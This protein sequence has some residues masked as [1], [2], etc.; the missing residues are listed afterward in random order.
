MT[1]VEAARADGL[2]AGRRAGGGRARARPVG[3]AEPTSAELAAAAWSK[4]YDFPVVS[5][6]EL[7]AL[8]KE[9]EAEA[10]GTVHLPR[11][12]PR[13]RPD[14]LARERGHRRRLARARGR[15]ADDA[16]A[17][18]FDARSRGCAVVLVRAPARLRAG[19]GRA[20]G[21]PLSSTSRR[22]GTAKPRVARWSTPFVTLT[23]T[24]TAGRFFLRGHE[25]R[26]QEF[27]ERRRRRPDADW[28]PL[29]VSRA[30][31]R[32][33][34]A[35]VRRDASVACS[36]HD[37][38]YDNVY[39]DRREDAHH[40]E[41]RDLLERATRRR[42]RR[43]MAP[44]YERRRRDVLRRRE[45]GGGARRVVDSDK[46]EHNTHNNRRRPRGGGYAPRPRRAVARRRRR[47]GRLDALR[48]SS[49]LGPG[50]NAHQIAKTTA[51][52]PAGVEILGVLCA[53]FV[54]FTSARQALADARSASRGAT[55]DTR[56]RRRRPARRSRRRRWRPSR[57]PDEAL[58]DFKRIRE[59]KTRARRDGAAR[60]AH[61]GV[62]RVTRPT[63][64][65][66][67][68]TPPWDRAPKSA[69]RA[70]AATFCANENETR[71]RGNGRRK[72]NR[73]RRRRAA[74][75]RRAGVFS[76]VRRVAD[77]AAFVL[78]VLG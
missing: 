38:V 9:M 18:R 21:S 62:L 47:R 67:R 50:R 10:G 6:A 30:R 17:S 43:R 48:R 54:L 41:A 28:E 19:N 61:G 15:A 57:A 11:G 1:D 72:L 71:R 76:G 52:V 59:T 37:V 8:A 46:N 34:A 42:R 16:S 35:A 73:K 69:L 64:R 14:E 13:V 23:P 66:R 58:A 78:A 26:W 55:D 40:R 29:E 33:G 51:R 3:G 4:L 20:A 75:R 56:K 53:P 32:R 5:P 77:A 27:A 2:D 12:R 60:R 7:D 22:R 36:E 49:R 45:R 65:A 44:P 24:R 39:D 25:T 68:G 70:A 31:R 74:P 63:P